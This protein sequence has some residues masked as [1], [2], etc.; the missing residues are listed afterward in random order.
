MRFFSL[1]RRV[2]VMWQ[3]IWNTAPDLIAFMLSFALLL[4]GF[5]YLAHMMWGHSAHT[6]TTVY[7]SMTSLFR[8]WIDDFPFMELYETNPG[9]SPDLLRSPVHRRATTHWCTF[10]FPPLKHV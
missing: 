6:F 2:S 4:L 10:Y 9:E 1:N 7:N 3:A 8:F 5:G